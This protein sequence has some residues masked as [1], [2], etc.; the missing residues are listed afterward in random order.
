MRSELIVSPEDPTPLHRPKARWPPAEDE[1]L[2]HAVTENG[3]SNWNGIALSLTGRTGKQC[4]ERWLSKLSPAFSGEAWTAAEDA[5]LVRLQREHGNQWA[6]FR[7]QLARRSTVAI[8]NRWVSLKRRGISDAGGSAAPVTIAI[9][10][11]AQ[12]AVAS[13]WEASAEGFGDAVAF[14]DFAWDF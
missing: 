6:T 5:T 2:L 1:V 7:S 10:P 9:V 13:D 3:P 12:M 11:C 8:K 4:R 14:D